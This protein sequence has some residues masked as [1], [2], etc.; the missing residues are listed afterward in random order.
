MSCLSVRSASMHLLAVGLA[1]SGSGC[2]DRANES[3]PLV[4][5]PVPFTT[6]K[7]E[8][9]HPWRYYAPA[10]YVIRDEGQWQ[11]LWRR[12]HIPL[13]VGE[14]PPPPSPPPVDFKSE[15]ILAVFQGRCPSGGYGVTISNVGETDEQLTVVV[16]YREPGP[17][18]STTC[19]MTNPYCMVSLPR[20]DKVVGFRVVEV[21]DH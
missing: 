10:H 8:K 11:R 4:L 17:D 1:I 18:E 21:E 7:Y 19:V 20:S 15:M 16:E 3:T 12:G 5:K 13:R 9:A 14:Q 6:L 2:K